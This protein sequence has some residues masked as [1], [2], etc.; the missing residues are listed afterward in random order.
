MCNYTCDRCS[1]GTE[2]GTHLWERLAGEGVREKRGGETRCRR[3]KGRGETER[4][5]LGSW[6]QQH[7]E[8]RRALN[9]GQP[10]SASEAKRF[11]LYPRNN[12]GCWREG[13]MAGT[14]KSLLMFCVG[15]SAEPVLSGNGGHP[16]AAAVVQK[17]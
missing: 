5:G 10:R 4:G 3:R 12:R 13:E 15:C 16:V 6:K 14:D 1:R 17:R 9:G 7:G 11:C 2:Q 8:K